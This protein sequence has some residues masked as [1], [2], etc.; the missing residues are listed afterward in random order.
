MNSHYD[1]DCNYV[2]INIGSVSVNVVSINNGK[3]TTIK[4][5]HKGDPVKTLNSII[6]QHFSEKKNY[7]CISGSFGDI[8]EIKAIERGLR[9]LKE[10]F[11]VI[12]SLG[13][14]SFVLYVLNKHGDIVNILSHDKCA[15]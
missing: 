11:D 13:G 3:V 15:A 10:D 5:A 8:S 12:L 1:N 14:E 9:V 6:E 4:V 2:G 7:F